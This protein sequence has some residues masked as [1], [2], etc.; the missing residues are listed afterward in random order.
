MII[1]RTVQ[2]RLGVISDGNAGPVTYGALLDAVVQRSVSRDVAASFAARLLGYAV[3]DNS[4]RL[5]AWIGQTAHES[6]CYHYL[7]ETWGPTP[8]QLRYDSRVDLGN[9]PGDGY[10]CRGAGWIQV[11]GRHWFDVIGHN[12]GVDLFNPANITTDVATLISLEWWKI[13]GMNGI[14]DSGDTTRVTRVVN[15]GT[16]GLPDRIML[17]ERA[18][19]L[20]Q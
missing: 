13:N 17:T 2:R 7:R 15:G 11:T 10:N 12:I 19:G 9:K 8:A 4:A 6:G 14:A 3:A 18:K 1:W 20:L 16:N 5:A